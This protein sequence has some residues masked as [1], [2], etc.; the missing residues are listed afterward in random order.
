MSGGKQ[1]T[2]SDVNL[3]IFSPM[4]TAELLTRWTVRIAVILYVVS[5][6]SRPHMP[7]FS[8]FSWIV[9]CFAYLLHVLAA[10][11]YYHHWSHEAAYNSTAQQTAEVTGLHWGGGLYVNY[12][13]TLVWLVDVLWWWFALKSHQSR[14]RWINWGVYLFLSF[15]VFNATVVFASGWS[16]WL[17]I[18]ACCL[19]PSAWL[20][21]RKERGNVGPEDFG[22]PRVDGGD[23]R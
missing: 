2:P 18:A 22:R 15:I 23:D 20:W 10:F 4:D 6:A 1:I 12:A 17:G 5:L 11:H 7:T 19:V 8:R 16:R 21:P 14:S 13:F 3:A 9:G